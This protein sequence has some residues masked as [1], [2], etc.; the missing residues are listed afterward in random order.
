MTTFTLT[1]QTEGLA[2][3][4]EDGPEHE[5]A[6]ML[7]VTANRLLCGDVSGPVLDIDGIVR[8]HFGIDEHDGPTV[9][10]GPDGTEPW[11]ELLEQLPG[12]VAQT[13][14]FTVRLDGATVHVS[15]YGADDVY[16]PIGTFSARVSRAALTSSI[17]IAAYQATVDA[18]GPLDRS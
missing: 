9:P 10:E 15:E 5:L 2:H 12:G 16:W 7:G 17:A 1:I 13:D 4:A 11:G 6:R 3:A 18:V 14:R 8:G